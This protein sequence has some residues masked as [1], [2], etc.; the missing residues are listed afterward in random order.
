VPNDVGPGRLQHRRREDGKND[1]LAHDLSLREISL[2][3]VAAQMP[4][5]SAVQKFQ[6]QARGERGALIRAHR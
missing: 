4:T 1:R 6:L 3:S 2:G 5:D